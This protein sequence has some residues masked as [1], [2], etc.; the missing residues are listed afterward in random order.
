MQPVITD[1]DAAT[2]I[3]ELDPNEAGTFDL[4]LTVT[5]LLA[6][7]NSP[8]VAGVPFPLNLDSSRS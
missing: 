6:D 3:W 2:W 7:T 1:T 5:P 4:T 8:L